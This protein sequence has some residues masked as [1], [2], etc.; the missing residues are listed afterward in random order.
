MTLFLLVGGLGLLLLVASLV[1][2]EVLDGLLDG[3]GGDILSTAAVAGFLAGFG[4]TGAVAAQSL[5]TGAATAVGVAGGLGLGAAA[6]LM[7]RSLSRSRTDPTP[8]SAALLGIAGTVVTD[9]P[10]QG[11]GEVSVVVAGH[12][13][14]L[15]ARA[16]EALAAGTPV[17]VTAV[18]SPTSVVVTRRT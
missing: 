8:T 1:V 10:S 18:L 5:G 15:N 13:G 16:D 7:T 6:G 12:L 2:G 14:K 11:Y 4:F 17:T 3:V 9:I